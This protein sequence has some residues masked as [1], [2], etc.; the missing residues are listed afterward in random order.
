MKNYSK[1]ELMW[2]REFGDGWNNLYESLLD[3]LKPYNVKI[4]QAKEKYGML[5]VYCEPYIEE[6]ENILNKYE[7]NDLRSL[8]PE[9]A[10]N[11]IPRVWE[12]KFLT[13]GCKVAIGHFQ[14]TC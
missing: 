12:M 11:R 9:N 4:V 8:M 10:H 1:E 14:L 2:G 7:K 6:V 3:E 13:V 5:R